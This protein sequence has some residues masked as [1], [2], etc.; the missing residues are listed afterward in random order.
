MSLVFFCLFASF[1]QVYSQEI[2][3]EKKENLK[4]N[5]KQRKKS[6]KHPEI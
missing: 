6:I 4:K 5:N 1:S 3:I 2:L